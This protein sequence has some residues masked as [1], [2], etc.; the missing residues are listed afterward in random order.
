MLPLNM[1]ILLINYLDFI[2]VVT[3][4]IPPLKVSI[5]Y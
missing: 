2:L 5:F 3:F 4:N 1:I